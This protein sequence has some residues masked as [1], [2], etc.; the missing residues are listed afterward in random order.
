MERAM[1]M[2]PQHSGRLECRASKKGAQLIRRPS[3]RKRLDGANLSSVPE[4][5]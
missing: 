5:E 2:K 3:P 1:P 4:G